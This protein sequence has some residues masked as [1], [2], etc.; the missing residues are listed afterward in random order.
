MRRF[1]LFLLLLGCTL[2]Q[3]WAQPELGGLWQGDDWGEVEIRWDGH[4]GTGTYTDTYNGKKGL[5]TFKASQPA[6]SVVGTWQESSP[7][8]GHPLRQGSLRLEWTADNDRFQVF[9]ESQDCDTTR[10]P[11]GESVWVR[12]VLT[13]PLHSHLELRLRHSTLRDGPLV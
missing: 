11:R 2:A 1:N 12:P 6:G 7:T 13:P 8:A 3:V 5:L 10:A 4:S 9:W